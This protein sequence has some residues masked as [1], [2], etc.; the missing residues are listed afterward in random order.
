MLRR[1][2]MSMLGL[3]GIGSLFHK[4]SSPVDLE[5]VYRFEDRFGIRYLKFA[6]VEP[7]K[8]NEYNYSKLN[9]MVINGEL[10]DKYDLVFHNPDGPAHISKERMDCTKYCWYLNGSKDVFDLSKP[11]AIEICSNKLFRASFKD[12]KNV[13]AKY[14]SFDLKSGETIFQKWKNLDRIC[15]WH[16]IKT[17]E[18]FESKIGMTIEKLLSFN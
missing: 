18:W 1:N 10:S 12:A 11:H 4:D 5:K 14:I 2:F 16:D 17:K 15:N 6:E 13:K 8:I 9:L 3:G 7:E